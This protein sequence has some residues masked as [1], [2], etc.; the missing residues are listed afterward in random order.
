MHD[1]AAPVASLP[2][3]PLTHGLPGSEM[4]EHLPQEHSLRRQRCFSP[5][6]EANMC[7]VQQYTVGLQL[8]VDIQVRTHSLILRP[9]SSSLGMRCNTLPTSSKNV[10]RYYYPSSN[11]TGGTI[12]HIVHMLVYCTCSWVAGMPSIIIFLLLEAMPHSHTYTPSTH[13]HPPPHTHTLHQLVR[14]IIIR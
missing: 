4:P 9:S 14:L 5:L 2:P 8:H 6:Q 12:H 7:S 1:L 13:T 3:P 10:H 11:S